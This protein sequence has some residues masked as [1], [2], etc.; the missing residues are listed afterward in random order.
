MQEKYNMVATTMFGLENLLEKELLELGAKEV[1]IGNRCVYFS[2]DK[3]LM[4][5]ANIK[6][7]TALKILHTLSTFTASKEFD[8]YKNISS[9][10]WHKI[11]DTSQTFSVSSTVN[12]R[13][14][15]HSNYVSL[16]TKDAI[17]DQFRKKYNKRPSVDLKSPD[18][19]IHIHISEHKCN[20]SLNSSGDSLHKRGYRSKVFSAPMNE[21]LAAGI[22]LLS[23]WD[24]N[25]DLI[26]PM[27]GSGTLLIEAGLIAINRAPN[28]YRKAFNFQKWKNYDHALLE[29]IKKEAVQNETKFNKVL[30]GFD[31]SASAI[32]TARNHIH[33]MKLSSIIK[34]DGQDFF[35]SNGHNNAMVLMNPPYGKRIELKKDYYKEI[36][37]TLKQKYPNT[38]AWIISSEFEE[39]KKIGLRTSKKIKLFNGALECKLLKFELYTGS[40]K[41]KKSQ[42]EQ[43]SM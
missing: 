35:K 13:H 11:L 23:N 15:K 12:S 3:A 20:L 42:N 7:R 34:I 2:G 24:K 26:D 29:D 25:Q 17:V 43:A 31:I 16:V 14:F 38:C 40:K 27:C 36:G 32:S 5:K 33:N 19:N 10:K 39:L 8:L 9:I 22:V 4:Y 6:L 37:D 28:I 30:K 41:I 18:I 1:K 21:V